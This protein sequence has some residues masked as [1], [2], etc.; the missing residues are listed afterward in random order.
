MNTLWAALIAGAVGVLTTYLAAVLKLRSDL[1]FAY[2]KDLREKRIPKYEELWKLTGRFPKYGRAP[3][4]TFS[5]VEELSD[6]L[7]DWYFTKGG[8]F[9]SDEGRNAY[10]SF[11]EGLAHTTPAHAQSATLDPNRYE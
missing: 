1:R 7:R 9:L 10:F 8:M 11:Q 5:D 4:L 3:E 6:Q 2:D